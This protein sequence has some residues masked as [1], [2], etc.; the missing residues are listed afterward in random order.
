M[1]GMTSIIIPTY[2]GLHLLRTCVEHIRAYTDVPYEIIVVDN[3]SHDGTGA[4]CTQEKLTLIS[5]PH[6]LGFPAAC[7]WGMRAARGDNLLLLNNDVYVSPR[8]LSGL[9]DALYSSE[10]VGI[11]GPVTNYASGIQ[12]VEVGYSDL[13]GFVSEADRRNAPG[14]Q[15]W[16]E[17]RRIVGLCYLFKRSVMERIGWLDE[18][19][20]PGHYEDDDY[21]YRARLAG[22]RLLV[23]NHVLVHHEGSASFRHR[24]PSGFRELVERNRRRFLN[25]WKVDPLQ[26]IDERGGAS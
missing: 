14:A 9:I 4:Y 19:Y 1:N 10:D 16:R 8:W 21:C 25:K 20:S 11:V 7:N 3:G 22:F 23:A 2:N 13:A 12:Q 6:N 15:D 17:V 18:L 24:F 5:L 26:F